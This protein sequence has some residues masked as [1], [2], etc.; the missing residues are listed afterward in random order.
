MARQKVRKNRSLVPIVIA[1]VVIGLLAGLYAGK[2]YILGRFAPPEPLETPP[3]AE[4]ALQEEPQEDDIPPAYPVAPARDPQPGL[5]ESPGGGPPVVVDPEQAAAI[6]CAEVSGEVESYLDHL[7]TY[8]KQD[9]PPADGRAHLDRMIRKILDNPPVVMRETDNLLTIRLNL[10]HFF[11]LLGPRD[12]LK[13]KKI[14]NR[15]QPS[16]EAS[17]AV[18]HAFAEMRTACPST[19]ETL[20]LPLE[21]LYEYAGFFLNTL[22]GKAYLYRRDPAL[23]LL[24]QYYAVLILDRAET[25]SMNRHGIDIRGSLTPLIKEMETTG[26]LADREHYL[27]TLYALE[28]KYLA[29]YGQ[30]PG[31]DG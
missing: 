13:I 17:M 5:E 23:R 6:S 4:R 15:E 2:E 21:K 22:G 19:K 31:Q 25:A 28:N 20:D 1:I 11:R 27:E 3:A 14:L 26:L 12:I 9:E 8:F 18:F 30:P 7:A 29:K 16:L 24:V 10:V